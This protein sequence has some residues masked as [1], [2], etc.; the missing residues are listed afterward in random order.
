MR[1][2]D[3]IVV[4]AGVVGPAVAVG[5]A[6]QGKKVLLLERDLREPDR[7]V[8]ELLQPGGVKALESLGLR[9]CLDGIDAIDV[10]GYEVF[11]NGDRVNIPY[12]VCDEDTGKRALGRSFH[13]GKFVMNLRKAAAETEGVTLMEATVRQMITNPHTGD[14]LG[15]KCTEKDGRERHYFAPLTVCSDGISSK[16]RKDYSYNTPE[17]KSHFAGLVL[18]NLT[19]PAPNHGNVVIGTKHQPIL[20]Y[21]I[22]QND[23]R[24]LCDIAGPVPSNGTGALKEHL[25][26]KVKP[27]L[28]KEVQQAFEDALNSDQRIRTMPSQYMPGTMPQTP[29]LVLL[30]D[31][32]NMRH[33]LTGGGMTVGLT[34]AV[35]LTNLLD[36][37]NDVD[38][39]NW[40]TVS[41][42]LQVFF[43]KRKNV[44]SVVNVLSVALY[45][46]FA[47][48]NEEL[49]ILQRGCFRYFQLGGECING[50]VS[51]LSG[52]LYR[53]AVLFYHF[54]SVAFYALYINALDNGLLKLPLSIYQ[55]FTTLWTA[56]VVF[57]PFLWEEAKWY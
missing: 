33:P 49:K 21:Q 23:T 10:Q 37:K 26:T 15:V 25:R 34:D 44:G 5:F 16:F 36:S 4:G 12:P 42:E 3:V 39:F 43:M 31:A 9:K 19:L 35:L 28:P 41:P 55:V 7:I 14:V 30:G 24:I 17:V 6:R 20:I 54:F 50:P 46:L 38:L 8:G 53:P 22:G 11:Y 40:D 32:F 2:F 45:S 48:A 57:L 13:H 51:L 56:C 52:L 29:G 18:H 1:E 27:H 47:G